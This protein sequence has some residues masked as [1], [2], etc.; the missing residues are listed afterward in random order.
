MEKKTTFTSLIGIKVFDEISQYQHRIKGDQSL[1]CRMIALRDLLTD[2][3]MVTTYYV[4][5]IK[6]LISMLST[7]I[8]DSKY[9][10]WH[11][12][13]HLGQNN[14]FIDIEPEVYSDSLAAWYAAIHEHGID[15][16]SRKITVETV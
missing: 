9:T 8:L 3:N 6:L 1:K 16:V 2:Y 12:V 10:E 14:Q 7:M 15:F 13:L 11:I 4:K 5:E